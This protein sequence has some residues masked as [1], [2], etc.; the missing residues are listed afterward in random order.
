MS[1]VS[2]MTAIKNALV[3]DSVLSTYNFEVAMRIGKNQSDK[4]NT[5]HCVEICVPEGEFINPDPII[6]A[7]TTNNDDTTDLQC[8][9]YSYFIKIHAGRRG[10]SDAGEIEDGTETKT[11]FSFLNDVRNALNK[12]WKLTSAITKY[13]YSAV[14]LVREEGDGDFHFEFTIQFEEQIEVEAR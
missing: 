9:L 4:A 7:G 11:I 3:A 13:L 14:S 5:A 8:E 10:F 12:A 2:V 6:S 1:Y